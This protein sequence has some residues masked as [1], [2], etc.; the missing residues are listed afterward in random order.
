MN[1]KLTTGKN[2]KASQSLEDL[3]DKKLAK[4]DRFFVGKT[5]NIERNKNILAS[6][7]EMSKKLDMHV[8]AEGVETE[9][10]FLSLSGMDCDLFQGFF[11]SK[12]IPPEEFERNYL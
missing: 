10:Q 4:L 1:F 11:F 5:E 12:A 2:F 9:A 8:V 6:I 3:L 7:I